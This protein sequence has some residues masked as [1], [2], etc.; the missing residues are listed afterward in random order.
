MSRLV[1]EGDEKQIALLMQLAE[2]MSDIDILEHAPNSNQS[3]EEDKESPLYWLDR[4]RE[5]GG[6]G[7]AIP[8]PSAWQREI[9]SWDRVLHG[10]EDE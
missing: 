8:D 3:N 6:L 7:Y 9:R 1:L 4:I 5:R 2:N 10:R